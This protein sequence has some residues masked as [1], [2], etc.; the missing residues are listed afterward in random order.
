MEVGWDGVVVTN[1]IGGTVLQGYKSEKGV[2]AIAKT[3]EVD[4]I[5]YA[6]KQ[7]IVNGLDEDYFSPDELQYV[8]IYYSRTALRG[9]GLAH[10]FW[11]PLLFSFLGVGH[12][13]AMWTRNSFRFALLW[14][15]S[16][17]KK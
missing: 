15:E 14:Q 8:A 17:V 12:S 3:D 5:Q 13:C 7:F 2:T 9:K 11:R 10:Q 1:E 4:F 6:R 16:W